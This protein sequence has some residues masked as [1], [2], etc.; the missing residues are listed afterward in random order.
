[1][2]TALLPAKLQM[3]AHQICNTPPFFVTFPHVKKNMPKEKR[4]FI[5]LAINCESGLIL[6]NLNNEM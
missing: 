3:F 1:M 5:K 2:R 6:P 4:K